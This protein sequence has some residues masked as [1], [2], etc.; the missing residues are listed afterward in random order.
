MPVD[1][2]TDEQ[3]RRYGRYNGDPTPSQLAR[4]F[5][6]DG[7]DHREIGIRRGT[8]TDWVMPYSCVRCVSW[9]RFYRIRRLYPRW[10][11][12]TWLGN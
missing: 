12:I 11:S 1:F 5:Y 3:A 2:L 8:T 9:A 6:L 7:R 10:W 4:H